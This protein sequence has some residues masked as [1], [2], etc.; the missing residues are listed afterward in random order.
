MALGFTSHYN[1]GEHATFGSLTKGSVE[2]NDVE[3]A[4][5]TAF[6]PTLIMGQ[7]SSFFAKDMEYDSC[8]FSTTVAVDYTQYATVADGSCSET[9]GSVAFSGSDFSGGAVASFSAGGASFS[10]GGMSCASFTC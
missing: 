9:A 4:G 6:V 1:N 2:T 10:G 7:D 3:S 8:E 5:T